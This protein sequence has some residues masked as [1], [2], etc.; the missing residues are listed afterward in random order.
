MEARALAMLRAGITTARDLGGG[1]GHELELRDRIARGEVPGPRLLCA[2]QP[3]TSPRGHCWFWGGEAR[4]EAELRAVVARQ[5]ERGADWIKVMATGGML[6]RGSDPLRA[7]LDVAGLRTVVSAA[8]AG[9]R[10]VAAHC[11]GTPGIRN[12]VAAGVATVEHCSFS[13]AEGFGSDFDPGLAH[14]IAARGV[15][16]SPTVN[17]GWGGRAR[18]DG[19]PTRFAERMSRALGA[20]RAAGARF[21]ASTDAGIP[22]VA[23]DRLAEGLAVF[24]ELSGLGPSGALRAATSSA[25]EALDLACE[26]GRLAVG[27]A[28]DVLVVEG[29]PLADLGALRRV[30]LVVARGR[31]VEGSEVRG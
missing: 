15:W 11:H 4:G 3:V 22:N 7:Q 31:P 1:A 17:A 29:D 18:R 19:T 25:A 20:L 23:H 2:G 21:V 28:A 8:R 10:R 13:G 9:G 5:L 12:A 26:T 6:T 16:V 14:Q 24:A 30:R 27:L